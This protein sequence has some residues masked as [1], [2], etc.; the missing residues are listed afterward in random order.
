MFLS[1]LMP[2]ILGSLIGA[3]TLFGQDEGR[4][5][6]QQL[7][8]LVKPTHINLEIIQRELELHEEKVSERYKEGD[9]IYFRIQLTNTSV[10]PAMVVVSDPYFQNR[11]QLLRDGEEVA[12]R[13][14][15]AELVQAKDKEQF[16]PRT[17]FLHLDSHSPKVTGILRLNDW[18]GTLKPG[19]YR[20]I[21]KH[22]FVPKGEWLESP[23][24]TFEIE[25][26]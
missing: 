14:K 16:F 17:N 20:L 4:G 22:R 12:Y 5:L 26:K 15:V 1:K 19:S 8:L 13:E 24:I 6:E 2:L 18:Y 3:T 25:P 21:N 9:N 23:P 11:P 10:V 7:A